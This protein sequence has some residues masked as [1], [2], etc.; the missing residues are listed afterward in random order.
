VNR[1]EWALYET[2]CAAPPVIRGRDFEPPVM[3]MRLLCRGYHINSG[4]RIRVWLLFNGQI[5]LQH[6][7]DDITFKWVW[8]ASDLHPTKRAYREDTDLRF[9]TLMLERDEPLT[10]TTWQD[11]EPN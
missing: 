3:G 10:F 1:Q 6:D 11:E 2:I 7:D 9:A 8:E 5:G 4:P